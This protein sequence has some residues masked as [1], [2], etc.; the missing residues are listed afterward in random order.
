M[1]IDMNS[2]TKFWILAARGK[3]PADLE[4]FVL[5]RGNLSVPLVW[6]LR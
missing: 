6:L 2:P 3:A 4:S 1:T 5:G